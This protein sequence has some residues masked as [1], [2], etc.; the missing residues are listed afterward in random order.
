[1]NRSFRSSNHLSSPAQLQQSADAQQRTADRQAARNSALTAALYRGTTNFTYSKDPAPRGRL[2]SVSKTN[3]LARKRKITSRLR[4]NAAGN[5]DG[6]DVD[7]ALVP[8]FEAEPGG[9]RDRGGR[10]GR[11]QPRDD[12]MDIETCRRLPRMQAAESRAAAAPRGRFDAVADLH[13]A[14][15]QEGERAD[16]IARAWESEMFGLRVFSPNAPRTAEILELSLD[17]LLIQR[18]IGPIPVSTLA[19]LRESP[20][21]TPVACGR[22]RLPGETAPDDRRRFNLLFPLLWLQ[23]GMPRTA[24]RLDCAIAKL[25][26]IRNALPDNPLATD[27]AQAEPTPAPPASSSE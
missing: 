26:A 11:E 7:G 24:I 10:G 18:R 19:R 4:R 16:A 23:A 2:P 13:A 12:P 14:P 5:G 20:A 15:G 9:D 1:M 21:P 17:F 27:D 22:D 25:L 3:A 6:D 8:H